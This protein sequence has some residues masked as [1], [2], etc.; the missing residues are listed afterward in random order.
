MKQ[1]EFEFPYDDHSDK[2]EFTL[3]PASSAL[4]KQ[5]VELSLP[6][7]ALI[8]L[9]ERGETSLVP[10]GG[11]VLKEG[12]KL[13]VLAEIDDIPEVRSIFGVTE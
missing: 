13:L 7:S 2:I 12:D 3:P 8:M 5:I 1:V 4:G 11:T 9:I 10:R 6:K